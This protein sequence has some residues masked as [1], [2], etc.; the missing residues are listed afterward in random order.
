MDVTTQP[1][2][3]ISEV[4]YSPYDE[5][6]QLK[7]YIQQ[8]PRSFTR[9]PAQPLIER[10]LTLSERTGPLALDQRFGT[11]ADDI[12]HLAPGGPRAIG[13]YIEVTGQILDED[14]SPLAGAMIEIWQAN[15][16]GQIYS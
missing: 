13:Q 14:G 3:A 8:Y 4:E 15:A 11:T 10:P 1:D 2:L 5:N 16:A 7:R 9:N 12:A 6:T